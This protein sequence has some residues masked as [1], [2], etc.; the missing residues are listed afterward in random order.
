MYRNQ[1]SRVQLGITA[2]GTGFL[3]LSVGLTAL[4]NSFSFDSWVVEIFGLHLDRLA[5]ST[6][7]QPTHTYTSKLFLSTT[8][9]VC[10]QESG[11]DHFDL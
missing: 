8:L 1:H 4:S 5:K 9:I 10:M 3:G 7:T 6:H 11:F 2:L